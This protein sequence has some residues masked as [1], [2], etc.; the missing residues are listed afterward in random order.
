MTVRRCRRPGWSRAM[1]AAAFVAPD[2]ETLL[3]EGF[4][5]VAPDC[6]IADVVRDVREW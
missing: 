5:Q 6:L 4:G 2:V 3:D 1:V